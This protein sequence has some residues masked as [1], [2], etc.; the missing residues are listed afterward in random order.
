MCCK[1]IK[2][3]LFPL[4]IFG[5]DKRCV[6][7]TLPENTFMYDCTIEVTGDYMVLNANIKG[8]NVKVNFNHP[9]STTYDLFIGGNTDYVRN[10][11]LYFNCTNITYL[12]VNGERL[13]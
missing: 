6:T 7:Y 10:H 3:I 5:K 4:N 2:Q 1:K 12:S 11:I 13:I 8:S 9:V